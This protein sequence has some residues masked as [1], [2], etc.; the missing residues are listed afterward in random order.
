[1]IFCNQC[2]NELPEG[3]GFC[4]ECGAAVPTLPNYEPA[5]TLP[6]SFGL[7]GAT[8]APGREATLPAPPP[9]YPETNFDAP[10]APPAAGTNS[11]LVMIV[12]GGVALAIIAAVIYIANNRS[13]TSDSASVNSS[14]PPATEDSLQKA[15]DGGRLVTLANDDAYT[16]F[17]QLK[18]SDPHSQKLNEIKSKVLPQLRNMGEE[19]IKQSASIQ[20]KRLTE[21]DWAIAQR[22]YEWAHVLEP[23]DSSLEARLK[24]AQAETARIQENRYSEERGYTEATQL[25]P[26]WALPQFRL[27]LLYMRRDRS[28]P[29][30]RN[31]LTRGQAAIPYFRR[32]ID[33]DSSW[34]LP[35]LSMGTAYYLQKDFETAKRYYLQA[36]TM[37]PDWGGPHAWMGAVYENTGMCHDAITEYEKALELVSNDD[38]FDVAAT[39]TKVEAIRSK[40]Y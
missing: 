11:K 12:I 19:V 16:Y 17:F 3:M 1:M 36:M 31:A 20:W 6:M 13:K 28:D 24:Y 10:P 34:E 40:C 26:K 22:V 39:R 32:A 9:H 2:G 23:N 21:R 29:N 38:S 35:Y 14:S 5:P 37:N 4:T 7:G 15:I 18:Q 27:G 25:D 30:D 33:L 8:T